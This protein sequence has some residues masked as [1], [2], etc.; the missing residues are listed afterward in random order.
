MK[1]LKADIDA[2]PVIIDLVHDS[3]PLALTCSVNKFLN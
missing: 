1:T 3:D 2:Q